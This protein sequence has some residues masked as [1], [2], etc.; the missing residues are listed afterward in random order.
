[1]LQTDYNCLCIG[2]SNNNLYTQWIVFE[3][4]LNIVR[5]KRTEIEKKHAGVK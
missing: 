3:K 4:F 1:M 5:L 2:P